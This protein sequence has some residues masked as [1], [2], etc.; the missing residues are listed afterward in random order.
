MTAL[1]TWSWHAQDQSPDRLAC[2]GPRPFLDMPFLNMLKRK[3]SGSLN[4]R[5][6]KSDQHQVKRQR[7]YPD[8]QATTA[9][10]EEG[11]TLLCTTPPKVTPL[12]ARAGN[13]EASSL[14]TTKP[15]E[16][17]APANTSTDR[18]SVNDKMD[19]RRLE[20]AKDKILAQIDL[21]ILLKHQEHRLIEQE[22]AK[23]QIS[24][25][26]LRR[27]HYVP[28]PGLAASPIVA[29]QVATGSGPALVPDGDFIRP[30]HPS[31]WGVTDGPYTRHYA[32]WLIQD[33]QFDPVPQQPRHSI[34]ALPQDTR[35]YRAGAI[36][37]RG[38]YA[39][40]PRAHRQSTEYRHQSIPTNYG[41]AKEK[42]GPLVIRRVS[43][44]QWVKLVCKFCGK[45]DISSTQ[46]FLNHCRIAH[47]R[48]Y[49]SHSE[50]A[51]ECGIP[52][53]PAD[54]PATTPTAVNTPISATSPA[55]NR[56]LIHPLV[57]NPPRWSAPRIS[58]I[59]KRKHSAFDAP[60]D[61]PCQANRRGS[62]QQKSGQSAPVTPMAVTP[63]PNRTPLLPAGSTRF[64]PS[65]SAPKLSSLMQRRGLGGDLNQMVANAKERCPMDQIE[66]LYGSDYVDDE[67]EE[68]QQSASS[69][70]P[71]PTRNTAIP[72]K[73]VPVVSTAI[74]TSHQTASHLAKPS[75][76]TGP[77]VI[78]NSQSSMPPALSSPGAAM[79]NGTPE[80]AST[81]TDKDH[82]DLSPFATS[83]NPGL[84]TDHEDDGD[85]DDPSE[86]GSEAQRHDEDTIRIQGDGESYSDD[87]PACPKG[88]SKAAPQL[89]QTDRGTRGRRGRNTKK[90]KT[91][92]GT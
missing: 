23:C 49:P 33:A 34:A 17:S 24:L 35:P 91:G 40:A 55:V 22:L 90:G 29:E 79:N 19:R 43:D 25:E 4:S 31:P 7:P 38:A 65:Q 62:K 16:A 80:N 70:H 89:G 48:T 59:Q 57:Q 30:P 1:S 21:E 69:S 28:Y 84:V 15:L 53:D 56:S 18:S 14:P 45:E 63:Q 77:A 74:G 46:G 32:Q 92:E 58:Q 36:Q 27:C 88:A 52:A 8:E 42:H 6:P 26:Q 51:N 66:S 71:A 85:V 37:E 72:G 20:Q 82:A 78:P 68:L 75:D 3:R 83:T 10:Q 47:Q 13:R 64:V 12:Q 67:D 76:P 11:P 39:G 54:V 86:H 2:A 61:T 9:S 81:P 50:A 73:R 44:G 41:Q 5:S 87:A 60:Q